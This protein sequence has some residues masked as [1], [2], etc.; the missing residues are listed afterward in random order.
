MLG[1]IV[2][3]DVFVEALLVFVPWCGDAATSLMSDFNLWWL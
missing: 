3:V 1:A 2:C